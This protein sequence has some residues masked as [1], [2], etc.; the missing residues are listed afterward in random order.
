MISSVGLDYQGKLEPDK[1]LKQLSRLV[2]GWDPP[3]RVKPSNAL[4][5]KIASLTEGGD[6]LKGRTE[7]DSH[8][9]MV[10]VGKH[11]W[12]ISRSKQSV[13][14]SAFADDVEGLK[15]VPIVDALLSY[16][17]KRT[18]K[19][20]LLVVRN[21]LYIESMTHNLIPPFI[22]REAGL[23]VNDTCRIHSPSADEHTHT[24]HDPKTGL[25]INL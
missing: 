19:T 9:N 3:V 21:A 7:L 23:I 10:V 17:C 4:K 18:M 24:I 20:Y 25:V 2:E 16:D 12:I 13:D 1:M 15:D 6:D 14:V 22:M 5:S 11:C 8:A